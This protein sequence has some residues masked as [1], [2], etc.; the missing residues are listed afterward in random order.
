MDELKKLLTH[1]DKIVS[2]TA[3]MVLALLEDV[4]N[5]GITKDE[6]N[7]L[8]DDVTNLALIDELSNSIERK[9][10]VASAFDTLK[11]ALNALPFV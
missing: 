4:K 11:T 2:S 3:T 9:A 8:V 1:E 10:A 6:F 5:G 7:E